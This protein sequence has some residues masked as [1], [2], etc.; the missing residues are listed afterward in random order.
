MQVVPNDLDD[1]RWLVSCDALPWL[2]RAET[3]S[4]SLTSLARQLRKGLTAGKV[5]LVLDQLQLRRRAAVKFSRAADMFFDVKLLEQAT[6]ERIAAY[7]AT[8]LRDCPRIV[9]LCCGLGGDLL[10]FARHGSCCGV[11]CD[12]IATLLSEAN[13]KVHGYDR[14]QCITSDALATDLAP[15]DTWHIDPDRRPAGRR[16]TRVELLQPT[17]EQISNLRRS[18]DDGCVKLA[19]ASIIDD[20]E[21]EREWI[22][23]RGE[24]RQQVV[25]CGTLARSHHRTATVIDADGASISLSGNANQDVEFVRRPRRF[26][27]EPDSTVLA[28]G[29][30]ELLAAQHQLARLVDTAGYLT[31]DAKQELPLA[32]SFEVCE[33]LSFD[34]KRIRKLL[35]DRQW[36]LES[37]KQRGSGLNPEKL[38][39]E[40]NLDDG[41]PVTLILAGQRAGTWAAIARRL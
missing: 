23:S 14:V 9:D 3:H 20:P 37:V 13:C 39:R 25:W 8:R 31:S 28:A 12:P 36:K 34:R 4:G 17:W 1:F 22:G 11:D 7:K 10:A 38:L 24:C 6:D 18:S 16:A 27:Y 5:H 40:L 15:E 32:A 41:D 21:V 19:A 35:R 2:R 26:L 33:V 29:L 30:A